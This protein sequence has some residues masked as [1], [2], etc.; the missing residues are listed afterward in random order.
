M[1]RKAY[2]K[3]IADLV[4]KAKAQKYLREQVFDTADF[5]AHVEQTAAVL[6]INP[7]IVKD[8]LVSY[9][10]NIFYVLNTVQKINFKINVYGFFS[11]NYMKGKTLYKKN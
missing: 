8:V 6:D 11:I 10:T 3:S 7:E 2:I 5:N 9:W 1:P 4:S